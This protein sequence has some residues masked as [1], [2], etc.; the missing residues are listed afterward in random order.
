MNADILCEREN[1]ELFI[2][3]MQK[4]KKS[5]FKKRRTIYRSTVRNI[6]YKGEPIENLKIVHMLSIED[7]K[8]N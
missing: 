6:L 4:R 2:I 3:E 8:D 5:D 1:K 7:Y